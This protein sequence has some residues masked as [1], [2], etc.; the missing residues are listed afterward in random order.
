MGNY[1]GEL[2]GLSGMEEEE[3]DQMSQ[4]GGF[5]VTGLAGFVATWQD[6]RLRMKASGEGSLKKLS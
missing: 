6:S 2:G 1:S 4:E 3:L 5:L